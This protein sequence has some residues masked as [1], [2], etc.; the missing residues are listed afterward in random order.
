MPDEAA[1]ERAI[2]RTVLYSDLF[3]Y[4]LT[5]VEIA[6]YLIEVRAEPLRIIARLD[7]SSWLAR[8]ITRVDGYVAVKGR[9]DIVQRRKDRARQSRRL[10]RKA[11]LFV[12]FLSCVPF[13]R[14][15]G[16]TGALSMDN[17]AERDD[18]D[19]MIV[20]APGRVWLARALAL[21][22]VVAGRVTGNTLCPNFILSEGTLCLERRSLYIAH[23]FAQ[24]VPLYGFEVYERMREVNRWVDE[25]L[26]N[27]TRPLR[28]L[29]DRPPGPVGSVIKRGLERLLGGGMG[30]RL[31]KWEMT[32]KLH[33]F[34]TELAHSDGAA[35]LSKDQVKGHF[36]DHGERV[37][38]A[39]QRRLEE[40]R[41][42]GRECGSSGDLQGTTVL[43][44]SA[45][46]QAS[47]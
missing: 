42:A 11:R 8:W 19:V 10:W 43:G 32:R 17:S 15:I 30:D 39:F 20:A 31:E 18:V 27:A 34:E 12:R 5:P 4:P 13:V 3:D 35:I 41:L 2:L 29:P 37:H 46:D 21:S 14:M 40:F 16:V 44:G 33:K 1:T 22:L 25:F 45:H 23:E 28:P 38:Q 26:P 9:E 47:R 7:A 6:H 36:N 24:M